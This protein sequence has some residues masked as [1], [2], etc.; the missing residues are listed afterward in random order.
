MR[1]AVV[2]AGHIVLE[3]LGALKTLGP[4]E[5]FVC[6]QSAATAE[7]AAERFDLAGG[8][9][10]FQEMM[11]RARPEV[12]HVRHRRGAIAPRPRPRPPGGQWVGTGYSNI[13]QG[14]R[15]FE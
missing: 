9:V 8:Y 15:I 12:V 13:P 5:V 10:D 6:D 3:H 4:L 14:I 7:D 1:A 11:H 2:G